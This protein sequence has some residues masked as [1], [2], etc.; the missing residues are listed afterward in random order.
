MPSDDYERRE[1][2]AQAAHDLRRWATVEQH[3]DPTVHRL[4]N[5]LQGAAV[6]LEWAGRNLPDRGIRQGLD[7]MVDALG[8]LQNPSTVRPW[9]GEQAPSV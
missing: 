3:S 4:R 5:L 7:T 9:W 2:Y 8:Q 1:R 6:T